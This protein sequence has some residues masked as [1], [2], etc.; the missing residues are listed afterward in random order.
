MGRNDTSLHVNI[1]K[2]TETKVSFYHQVT[3]VIA[4]DIFFAVRKTIKISK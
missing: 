2:I 1:L 4:F 3:F